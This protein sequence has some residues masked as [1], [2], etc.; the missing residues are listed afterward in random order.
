MKCVCYICG[1]EFDRKPALIKR[2]ARPVC[3]RACQT[4]LK[5]KGFVST[6]CCICGKQLVRRQSRLEIRP[7]PVCSAKCATEVKRRV[8]IDPTIT[9]EQRQQTRKV[10]ERRGFLKAVME[11]DGYKCV[12]CGVH[13]NRMFVHHLN[14]YNWD[15]ENRCNPDNGVTLCDGC[16]KAFHKRYGKGWNTK[17]Q[18]IE[19]A[20]QSGRLGVIPGSHATHRS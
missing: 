14:G 6:V 16:H 19:Y 4:I 11:R 17:E 12:L 20:N 15:V 8:N 3:S 10:P 18:F 1:K 5:H 2:A 9:D 13:E 7:N